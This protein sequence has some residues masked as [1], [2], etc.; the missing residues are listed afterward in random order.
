MP[1]GMNDVGELLVTEYPCHVLGDKTEGEKG[2]GE[3]NKKR[4]KNG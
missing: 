4:K 2:A 1:I 3:R